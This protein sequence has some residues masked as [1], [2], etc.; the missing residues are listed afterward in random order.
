MIISK[1]IFIS[2][3]LDLKGITVPRFE[4][5]SDKL[6][7]ICLPIFDLEGN[8]LRFNFRFDL[9]KHF[10]NTIPNLKW[11]KEYSETRFQK[12]FKSISVG[13]YIM[14]NLNCTKEQAE[15]IAVYLELDV[16]EK[17]KKLI[18]GKGKALAIKCDFEKYDALVFDYYGVGGG[19]IDYLERIVDAEIRKGKSA[20]VLDR[21]EFQIKE[22]VYENIER[23]KIAGY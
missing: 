1:V 10:Q 15:I 20:I 14:K 3:Q 7:R 9:L 12:L 17:V 13:D 5:K 18:I 21:L 16:D 22:E 19:E 4:L 2:P 23:V 8:P 6:I 11:S